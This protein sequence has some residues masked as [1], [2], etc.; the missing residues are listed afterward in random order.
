MNGKLEKRVLSSSTLNRECRKHIFI[1]IT[2]K[3]ERD[4]DGNNFEALF[5]KGG[6][7][8]THILG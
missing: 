8:K 4:N 5:S 1:L 6:I 7:E 2:I 3:N